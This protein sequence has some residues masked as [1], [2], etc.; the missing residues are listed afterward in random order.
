MTT[1]NNN[2]RGRR[3]IKNGAVSKARKKHQIAF[4]ESEWREISK[5]ARQTNRS[6]AAY[7]REVATKHRPMLPDPQMKSEL[8]KIRTDIIRLW[9]FLESRSWSQEVRIKMMSELNFLRQWTNGVIAELNWIDKW[10]KR[11]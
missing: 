1:E 6:C 7:I 8:M 2:R 11:L 9:G 5:Y 3:S 10:I 4:S